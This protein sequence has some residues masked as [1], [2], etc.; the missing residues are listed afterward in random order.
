MHAWVQV[1]QRSHNDPSSAPTV[2]GPHPARLVPIR[3]R[4]VPPRRPGDRVRL[5]D[6]VAA[7]QSHEKLATAHGAKH[8]GTWG[9]R[10]TRLL[11]YQRGPRFH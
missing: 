5:E 6:A 9:Q 1:R 7:R 8:T 2:I 10:F 4:P 11:G 3:D